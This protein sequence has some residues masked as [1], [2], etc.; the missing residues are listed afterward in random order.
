VKK[1]DQETEVP[2]EAVPRAHHFVP[3]CWLAGFTETGEKDGR[4][5]VTD[6]KRR[7]QWPSNPPNAGHS[8]DFYRLSA[9]Q[10]DPVVVERLLSKIEDTIA[11]LLKVLDKEQ[12]APR[13]DELEGLLSFMAIQWVR[14]PAFRPTILRIADSI[15]RA[16]IS[17]ALK[18]PESWAAMLKDVN[19]SVD[20]P[21]ADYDRMREFERSGEYSL[22][23]ETEWYILKA[24]ESAKTITPLLM[25]RNW[26]VSISRKGGFVGSDNPVVL[27]G[28]KGGMVGFKSAD[29]VLYPVSRHVVLYG[30]KSKERQPFVN[31][32]YIARLNTFMMITAQEQIFSSSS[33]FCWLDETDKYQTDWRLFRKER[34][35]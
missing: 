1:A 33:E 3:Q 6:L 16:R 5:W 31:Q 9:P 28:P 8:R 25:K 10:P 34:Y 2:T 4:L 7:N 15:H 29:I 20:D 14:V 32:L 21:A 22:S 24:F 11:P 27:D 19:V 13:Q 35:G 12:R 18:G 17:E 23:A 26:D 30:T